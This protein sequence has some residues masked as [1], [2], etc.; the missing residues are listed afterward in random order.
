MFKKKIL[1]LMKRFGSNKDMVKENF[2]REIRLFEQL[3]R[4]Y[5]IDFLCFDYRKKQIFNLR[6]SNMNFFVVPASFLNPFAMLG[7]M[8]GMMRNNKY[9]VVV[10]TTEPILGIIGYCFAKIYEIP[11]IYEVQDNYEIYDSYKIPFVRFFDYKVIKNADYVFFSNYPLME[12]H[13]FLRNKKIEIIENGIDLKFFRILPKKN[14][15]ASLRLD[16]NIKLITY[17][18]SISKDRGLDLLIDAVGELA[19]DDKKVHLL[20]SGKVDE[21]ININK[22]WVIFREFPKREQIVEAL[23][24]SD[25]LVLASTDNPFTRYSFPQKLFEYMSVNVSIVATEVGDV[26]RI[27][28]PFKGSLCKPNNIKELKSKILLQMKR[29]NINY[30]KTAMSYTWEKLSKRLDKMIMQVTK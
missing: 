17:T 21:S 9:N 24:A 6:R 20:L 10:P 3:S 28:K 27:L 4:K 13:K 19:K 30:R 1:V 23:N 14:A 18:G 29:K 11:I 5:D 7:T 12:K 8:N 16:Q 2:G 26:I 22:P 15:R 25:L